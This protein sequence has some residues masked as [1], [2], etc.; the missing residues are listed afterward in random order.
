MFPSLLHLLSTAAAV[1]AVLAPIPSFWR[2]FKTRSTDCVSVLPAILT[3]CNCYT[4]AMY[5]RVVNSIPPLFVVYAV[6]MLSSIL[7]AGIYYHWTQD[8]ARINKLYG[9]AFYVLAIYTLYYSL[10]TSGATN[11]SDNAVG[12]TLGVFS[13]LINLALYASPLE[14][15]KDVV[16]NKDASTIPIA[17]SVLLLSNSVTWVVHSEVE[18]DMLVLVPNAIGIALCMA[19]VVLYVIYYPSKEDEVSVNC[20]STSSTCE[21]VRDLWYESLKE[22]EA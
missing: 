21:T 17:I 13:G 16:E 7:C 19:Q 18:G 6:G 5:A 10:G 3:F 9:V 14:T 2:V 11:Q 22:V 8:H 15:A 12:N 20:G 1:V 4:W